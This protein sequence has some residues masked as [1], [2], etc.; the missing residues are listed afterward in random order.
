MTLKGA[1][2]NSY[3]KKM[4]KRIAIN[5]CL[6]AKDTILPAKSIHRIPA[7]IETVGGT[8]ER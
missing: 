7:S 2:L 3:I 1:A 8:G 6:A 4:D 5:K